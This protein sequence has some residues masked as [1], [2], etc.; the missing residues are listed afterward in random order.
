MLRPVK[1]KAKA[2]PGE[3]VRPR[4]RRPKLGLRLRRRLTQSLL[5]LGLAEVLKPSALRGTYWAACLRA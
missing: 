2:K 4:L 3:K 1:A 5:R